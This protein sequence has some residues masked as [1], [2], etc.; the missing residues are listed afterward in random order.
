M[1]NTAIIGTG[2]IARLH[3]EGLL[4]YPARCQMTAL[5]NRTPKKAEEINAK[6]GL[7]AEVCGDYKKILERDDVDFVVICTPPFTHAEITVAALI[8]GKH[9]LVEK[10]MASSLEECDAMLEAAEKSGKILSVVAQNRFKPEFIKLKKTLES[11]L[12]GKILHAQVNSHWWR[13]HAYYDTWWRG[14][15]DKEGGGCT[16]N[17][18]VHHIDAMLWMTG[19]P[20]EVKAMTA[21]VAHDNAEVEDLS[22]AL[23]KFKS[24]AL[25]QITS[26]VVHHGQEQDIIF[27]CEK[28][29]ISAPWKIYASLP[30]EDGFPYSYPDQ[31][32]QNKIEEFYTGLRVK[33]Y[34]S[35]YQAQIDD[36]LTAI[37]TG[38]NVLI[39]GED[40]RKTLELITAVYKSASS[41]QTVKLPLA[42]NDPFYTARGIVENVKRF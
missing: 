9:V 42:G 32:T 19:L 29:R 18:A 14:T 35:L 10:P 6:Y 8:A 38:S 12:A 25:G 23:L 27:Q 11:G 22:I 20:L 13:G 31:N 33:D 36:V 16:L 24:G 5:A 2:N 4:A 39:N 3:I 7:N 41:D 21:N 1:I 37:E 15:W 17:H 28:A 40:G 30:R 34:G 26:S